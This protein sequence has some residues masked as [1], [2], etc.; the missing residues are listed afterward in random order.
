[1][2]ATQTPA[3]E[4][5][6][7]TRDLC[8]SI[9]D[10]PNFPQLKERVAAF[11]ADELIKFK[12]QMVTER[13]NLLQLK[14][15]AGAELTDEEVNTFNQ[16]REDLMASDVARNFL[17]AQQEVARIQDQVMRHL[18]LTFELGRVP[19]DEDVNDGC[20]SSGCGCH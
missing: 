14:Q 11:M 15:N 12:F 19:S 7:K 1:M 10:L 17:E 8:Q 20:C 16:L 5:T 13:G 18:T 3:I 6:Q 4:L 2:T 9:V